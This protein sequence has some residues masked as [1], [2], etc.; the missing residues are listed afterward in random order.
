[1]LLEVTKK[2]TPKKECK[3]EDTVPQP[4]WWLFPAR[5]AGSVGAAILTP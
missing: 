5:V 3:I 4:P 1:L 2:C